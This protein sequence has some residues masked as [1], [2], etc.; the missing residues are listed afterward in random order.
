L[1]RSPWCSAAL[2]WL[3]E[4]REV[5][6]LASVQAASAAPPTTDRVHLLELDPTR[7]PRELMYR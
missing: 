5:T 4:E 6:V 2:A 3:L 1:P 7:T